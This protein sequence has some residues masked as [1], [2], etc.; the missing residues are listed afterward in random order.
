MASSRLASIPMEVVISD[1][2]GSAI[3]R[4]RRSA[5]KTT[6]DDTPTEASQITLD[7]AR[8]KSF[9][10]HLSTFI[11]REPSV[12]MQ[13]VLTYMDEIVSTFNESEIRMALGQMQDEK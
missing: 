10:I 12:T 8:F 5:R 4:Q 7:P 6:S 2:S 1:G 9:K 13:Q 3:K 11:G